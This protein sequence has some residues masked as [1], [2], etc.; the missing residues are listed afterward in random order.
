[1]L[2][3]NLLPSLVGFA[4][5]SGYTRLLWARTIFL[6]S[7]WQFASIGAPL[8]FPGALVVLQHAISSSSPFSMFCLAAPSPFCPIATFNTAFGRP[9]RLLSNAPARMLNDTRL[10]KWLSI[11]LKSDY[12]HTS[13]LASA[14]HGSRCSAFLLE[15]IDGGF[16]MSLLPSSSL[17][18]SARGDLTD[19][20]ASLHSVIYYFYPLL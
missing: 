14:Q 7:P 8:E 16:S 3:C 6:R 10:L 2:D 4:S 1:M 11:L 13:T 20:T 19:P 12:R 15:P 5:A 18:Y 9:Q 17:Q